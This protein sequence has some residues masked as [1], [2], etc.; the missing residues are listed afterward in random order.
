MRRDR[1]G[2]GAGEAVGD[3]DSPVAAI[4]LTVTAGTGRVT[5]RLDPLGLRT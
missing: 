3:V 5:L 4:R 2:V 1:I